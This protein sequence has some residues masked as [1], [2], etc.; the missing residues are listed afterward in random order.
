MSIDREALA[1]ALEA[2]IRTATGTAFRL[3]RADAAQLAP[4]RG[5]SLSSGR[6]RVFC[7][8]MDAASAD[9]LD[10]ECDGLAAIAAT[11]TFRTPDV[12]GRGEAAGAAWMVLE[13][14]DLRP[15]SD[16]AGARRAALL[17]AEMHGPAH[18]GERF[19]WHR[20]NYL[21]ATPQ[22][23]A[24]SDNWS[25]FF[26]LSRLQPQLQ[27]AADNGLDKA[28]AREGERIITRLPAMF[29]DYRPA[30]SL[31][32]GDLWHGN[33]GILPDGEPVVFDPACHH[34][35]RDCDLAM[36]ELFGGLPEAFYASYRAELS[37][38]EGYEARKLAYTLYHL[39][40]HLNLFG[41]SY[42]S[43]CARVIGLLAR[44]LSR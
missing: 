14:L 10:A 17:L 3:S 36:A 41:R 21:G 32:H 39:L 7:K 25:R 43:A 22:D 28:L 12:L 9:R 11:G 33:L 15:I 38:G 24:P 8:L 1:E 30:P 35:D 27:R 42:R 23:N 31:L 6:E 16:A 37:P 20:S 4:G 18:Q 26:A 2:A 13:W 34:G 44:E 29:L 40:N 5:V 19:G